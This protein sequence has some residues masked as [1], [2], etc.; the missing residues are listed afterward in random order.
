MGHLFIVERFTVEFKFRNAVIEN[1]INQG[2]VHC[3]NFSVQV[4]PSCLFVIP[5]PN[6]LKTEDSSFGVTGSRQRNG[7]KTPERMLFNWRKIM[8]LGFSTRRLFYMGFQVF[9]KVSNSSF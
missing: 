9:F 8:L 5:N 6:I 4:I 3:T 7:H 2:G 1:L